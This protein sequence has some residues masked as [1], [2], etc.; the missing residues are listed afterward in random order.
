M[1]NI[2]AGILAHVDSGTKAWLHEHGM[3]PNLAG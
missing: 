1:K 3:S 2:V